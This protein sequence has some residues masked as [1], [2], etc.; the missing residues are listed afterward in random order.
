MKMILF[1]N[2]WEGLGFMMRKL[3]ESEGIE[4]EWKNS[5]DDL[6]LFKKHNI[7]T[8]PVLLLLDN[9][10]ESGRLTSTQEIIEYL[11]E[12][13]QDIEIPMGIE[14]QALLDK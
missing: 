1:L 10:A 12:N 11:K 4:M 2:P 9:E 3:L 13:V 6:K 5:K 14:E 7:K 8:T